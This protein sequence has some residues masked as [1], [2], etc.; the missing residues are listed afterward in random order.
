MKRFTGFILMVFIAVIVGC[1]GSHYQKG[2]KNY[3][4]EDAAAA[5]REL[6]PLAES[7]RA[8]AQFN[9]GS[10]YY[11]GWGLPQDYQEAVRWFRK[12][13]EQRHL[14]AQATL[15]T[16]YAEGVQGVIAKDYPQALMWFIFAAAQG[17]AEAMEFRNTLAAKMTPAQITEA[18]RMARE[19]K[20]EDSYVKL[21]RDLKSLAEKGDAAAQ[22]KV[23][24]MH[25]QGRGAVKDLGEA[26]QWFR[27]SALQ[28]NALAQANVG[29]M[30]DLGEGVPQNHVEA[31]E[32]YLKAAERGNAQAQFTLGSM[33]EKG[34]GVQQDEVQAL[35][36]FNLAAA[37]GF[38]KAKAARDRITVWMSPE[39]IAEAQRLAREFR[40]L[41]K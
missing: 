37:Q 16:I 21:Y 34:L 18:Q 33:Y 3:R 28:G 41:G 1:A 4:P 9:L 31:A 2:I 22:L 7:G 35:L 23:G 26:L 13:A 40:V 11:Q 24:L 39:Q 12:A 14:H 19:F 17:D 27:K 38:G 20:P 36:W 30:Y 32:W 8:D 6:L 29:Y 5:V 15:G 10:L 25:Y